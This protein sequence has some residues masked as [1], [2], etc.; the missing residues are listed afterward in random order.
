MINREPHLS[1]S[2]LT[3]Q[4]YSRYSLSAT[5]PLYTVRNIILPI[6]FITTT[7]LSKLY[8]SHADSVLG[9][10]CIPQSAKRHCCPNPTPHS[11][12][13]HV[14][15]CALPLQF[16]KAPLPL[17]FP[18]APFIHIPSH[19]GEP[20]ERRERAR[21]RL[22]GVRRIGQSAAPANRQPPEPSHELNLHPQQQQRQCLESTPLPPPNPRHIHSLVWSR[23]LVVCIAQN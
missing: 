17:L 9:G 14:V 4:H 8:L 23:S 22:C 3:L 16:R 12:S 2:T 6:I 13:E 5:D 19:G 10:L 7:V 20:E 15:R 1:V 18:N 11:P 21:V